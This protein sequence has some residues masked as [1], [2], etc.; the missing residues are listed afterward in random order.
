MVNFT[1]VLIETNDNDVPFIAIYKPDIKR[2][3]RRV[4][5]ITSI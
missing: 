5:A 1:E 2:E 4:Q 3:Q